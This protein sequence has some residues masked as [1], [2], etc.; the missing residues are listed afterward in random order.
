MIAPEHD[1]L[2]GDNVLSTVGALTRITPA[3][4]AAAAAEFRPMLADLPRPLVTVLLGGPNKAYR[5]SERLVERLGEDLAGLI[6]RQNCGLA[7]S[8]S[9]RTGTAATAYLR[10]R[11]QGLPAIFW[12][13]DG[14]NPYF[15]LLAL[16]DAILV[17]ADSI[18]MVS[19]ASS[20]G[21]PVHVIALE[22]GSAKF[23]RFHERLAAAGA[24]RPF[25]GTIEDWHYRPLAE[26]ARVGA[27]LGRRL[28]AHRAVQ[29]GHAA[30]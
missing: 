3:R 10:Q 23:R 6:E 25:T 27:E 9:R 29:D 22:G 20:T 15:G 16:A 1:A 18:N 28:A 4:L 19:E 26:T 13:G 8:A 30:A 7:I 21:K 12:E 17:T 2:A 14:P 24:T 5:M 11:L